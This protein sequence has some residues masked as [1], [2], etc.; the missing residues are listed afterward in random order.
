MAILI[1]SRDPH[2]FPQKSHVVG[3]MDRFSN[4][5]VLD[6]T[7]TTE[8]LLFTISGNVSELGTIT[9]FKFIKKFLHAACENCYG[10]K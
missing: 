8:T 4:L 1:F 2:I 7:S 10:K 3:K 5:K 6:I 9:E